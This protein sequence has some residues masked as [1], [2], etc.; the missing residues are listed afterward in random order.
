MTSEH[1]A[2]PDVTSGPETQEIFKIRTVRI[3]GLSPSRTPD[4]FNKGNEWA[5]EHIWKMYDFEALC[6]DCCQL[7][8]THSAG[9]EK[10]G[11]Q[12][13]NREKILKFVKDCLISCSRHRTTKFPNSESPIFC[14]LAWSN[15]RARH[16]AIYILK[17]RNLF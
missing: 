7:F 9:Q 10:P 11:A 17:S 14:L 6:C 12:L 13:K 16:S 8:W 15:S 3:S 1:R 4:I 5:L 2:H